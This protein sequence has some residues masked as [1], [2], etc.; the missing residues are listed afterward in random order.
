MCFRLK[1]VDRFGDLCAGNPVNRSVVNLG[2]EREAALRY[3][4]DIVQAFD[5]VGLPQ[6]LVSIERARMQACRLD[7]QLTPVT[8]R[9]QCNMTH[10]ELEIEI[11]ILDPVRVIKAKRNGDDALTERARL[12]QPLPEKLQNFLEGDAS[13]RC[14]ALIVNGQAADMHR[15]PAGFHVQE[16]GVEARKLLHSCGLSGFDRAV[17]RAGSME[18]EVAESADFERTPVVLRL[19]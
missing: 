8:R 14:G 12:V 2:Y 16:R 18:I 7:A 11:G 4:F 10:V 13:A 17:Q 1:V 9:R 19:S 6:R 3:A 5:N 15:R